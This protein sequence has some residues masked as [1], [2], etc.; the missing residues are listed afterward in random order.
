MSEYV[1]VGTAIIAEKIKINT[2]K[3]TLGK[4]PHIMNDKLF[5]PFS[6]ARGGVVEI[7]TPLELHD[8]PRK[9]LNE[10]FLYTEEGATLNAKRLWGCSDRLQNDRQKQKGT[11]DVRSGGHSRQSMEIQGKICYAVIISSW[12]G[13]NIKIFPMDYLKQKLTE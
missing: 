5:Y 3:V 2:I 13:D 10:K 6:V 1:E 8:V 11:P 12:S 4:R 7:I 9:F